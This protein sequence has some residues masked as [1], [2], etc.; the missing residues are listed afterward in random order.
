MSLSEVN[1]GLSGISN[2]IIDGEAQTYALLPTASEHTGEIWAVLTSTGIYLINYRSAGLYISDGVNWNV[3]SAF[4]FPSISATSP[5]TYNSTTGEISTNTS[6]NKLIGRYSS[7]SGVME[8]ITVGSGLNLSGSGILSATGSGS[9]TTVSVATANGFA[10]TVLN[11]S[12]TPEIT[13]STTVTGVLLGN[14]TSISGLNY[15]STNTPSSLVY[16]DPDGDF[17]ARKISTIGLINNTTNDTQALL[18]NNSTGLSRFS[19]DLVFSD[20]D[21]RL[22]RYDDAGVFSETALTIKRA[23]GG[24]ITIAGNFYSSQ[25]GIYS[26]G[27]SG[28]PWFK[29]Y[30]TNIVDDGF[31]ITFAQNP[32]ITGLT[33]SQL[34]ATDGS[35][36][37]LSLQYSSSNTASAIVAR[38]SNGD[39]SAGTI[40]AAIN[41]NATTATTLQTGRTIS[42]SG[43][44]TYTSP[45]FNGSGNVTAAGT[46]A[47][48]NANIGSFGSSTAI[49]SFTVNAKGLITAA[50]TSAVIAPAGTLIGTTLA[51]NV[52]TSSLTAVGTIA[53]GT[54]NATTIAVNKGGTGQTS[55]VNGELMIGNT[56][57][58]TL[59]KATLTGTADQ[60][61]VTNGAGSIIL[62]T[63]QN[64]ATSSTPTFAGIIASGSTQ[65]TYK[66][67]LSG[68]E[69]YQAGNS[70]ADGVALLAGVNRAG[71][72][73]L[74]IADSATLAQN[75]T[76]LALRIL[77]SGTAPGIDAIATNGTTAL[78]LNIQPGGGSTIFGGDVVSGHLTFRSSNAYNIGTSSNYP[79]TIFSNIIWFGGYNGPQDA[80]VVLQGS[81]AVFYG[82]KAVAWS[83]Y[84]DRDLKHNIELYDSE[85]CLKKTLGL[86]V[87]SYWWNKNQGDNIEGTQPRAQIG[88]IAQQVNQ[89]FWHACTRD[90]Q[91]IARSVDYGKISIINTGAIQALY[92]RINQLTKQIEALQNN[93]VIN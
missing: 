66:Y 78:N 74:W 25:G 9:V 23:V 14:G 84:S 16:R 8:E 33:A 26:L 67:L 15:N 50:S 63:P 54:W 65:L 10:G 47:T 18:I 60:V 3:F 19:L 34:V 55:F 68:Q 83:I 48:V 2:N 82:A 43:D 37:L 76:N 41:G 85:K 5:I 52:V 93:T 38:D 44:L 73:Q 81:N 31:S 51:S 58:N 77:I 61:T 24:D 13:L 80:N 86:E 7:G 36:K 71:N 42:I 1:K 57:G 79:N 21:F 59:T 40:N 88:F 87:V 72:R 6:V 11:P 49:P 62:S 29:F 53:T 45:S 89:H 12:T 30:S 64:I 32:T 28:T 4:N 39:F 69:F 46:L 92:E 20:N 75:S 70:A 27:V 35:K 22:Q 91:G 17:S 56:T 90:E